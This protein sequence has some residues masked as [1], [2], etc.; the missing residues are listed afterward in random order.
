MS[1]DKKLVE[2]RKD[3]DMMNLLRGH[4]PLGISGSLPVRSPEFMW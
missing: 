2:K 4:R 1:A 3:Y